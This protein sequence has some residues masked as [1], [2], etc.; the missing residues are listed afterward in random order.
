MLRMRGKR[1]PR[2]NTVLASSFLTSFSLLS[3]LPSCIFSFFPTYFFVSHPLFLH[4]QNSMFSSRSQ[5]GAETTVVTAFYSLIFL[6]STLRGV[7]FII[8]GTMWSP[9]YTP[10]AT[11]AFSSSSSSST[12][13]SLE[14]NNSTSSS[15]QWV[16]EFV[17]QLLKS[18]GSLSLFSIFILILVYWADI[19]KKYFYPDARRSKPM[20]TFLLLV[21]ALFGIQIINAILFLRGYYSTEGMALINSITLSI[22]SL[23]CVA[24][25]TIFSH[26]FRTVLKTLGDIN[27]VPTDSQVKRIVWITITGN[28]FF[29]TRAI[30]ET[31]FAIRLVMYYKVNGTVDEIFTHA[32]W[33]T[34]LLLKHY[35]ELAILALMLYILQSRFTNSTAGANNNGGG[36]TSGGGGYQSVPETD[37]AYND[38]TPSKLAV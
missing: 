21:C 30:L 17:E 38:E 7:W 32:V 29:V 6:T 18:A 25:I 35:S 10:H 9:Y 27:Q 23:V 1:G 14:N 31:T 36:E 20:L 28:L 2:D 33:D 24:E 11:M 34:F 15:H 8:P 4:A 19:L 5:G 26:R 12:T 3:F 16:W 22:V 13:S 37:D